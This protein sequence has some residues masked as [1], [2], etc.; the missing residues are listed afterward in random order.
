MAGVLDEVLELC[1]WKNVINTI[2]ETV[3]PGPMALIG[4]RRRS[5]TATLTPINERRSAF[6]VN[7]SQLFPIE[8]MH[9]LAVSLLRKER[10]GLEEA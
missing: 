3:I 8:V 5:A 9:N 4:N 6:V 10:Q 1:R 2:G 7:E